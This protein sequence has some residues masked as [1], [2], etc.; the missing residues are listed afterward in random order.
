MSFEGLSFVLPWGHMAVAA[1]LV[2]A[3]MALSV[4]Y[5]LHRCRMDSVVEAL[6]EDAI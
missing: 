4:A 6:R 3:A 1:A 2:G 5:G